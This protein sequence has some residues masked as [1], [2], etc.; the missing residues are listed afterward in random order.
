[1]KLSNK[2]L[3]ELIADSVMMDIDIC[4]P[5]PIRFW[6]PIP[7][8]GRRGGWPW[9]DPPKP[10]RTRIEMMYAMDGKKASR[11]AAAIIGGLIVEL[12]FESAKSL[13]NMDKNDALQ[14]SNRLSADIISI[15]GECG[16]VPI[17]EIIRRILKKL[18]IKLPPSP[19]PDP[20]PVY[21]DEKFTKADQLII[22]SVVAVC[23]SELDNSA[24]IAISNASFNEV[25]S[26]LKM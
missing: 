18:G 17:R 4:P 1:M 25:A 23:V 7:R 11:Y 19:E 8:P 14:A 20:N 2:E 15:T 22:H 16:T 12:T 24:S 21:L 9:P 10:L 6:P 5:Y 26:L 13:Q 3:A